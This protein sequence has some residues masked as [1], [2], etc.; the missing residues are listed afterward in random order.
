MKKLSFYSLFCFATILL[1]LSCI[2]NIAGLNIDQNSATSIDPSYLISTGM[3]NIGGEYENTRCVNIHASQFIQHTATTT[4][5][6]AGGD[7]YWYNMQYSGAYMERH[8]T[9]VAKYFS[10]AIDLTKDKPTLVN[11]NAIATIIRAFDLHRM[12]DIYGDIPYN[13]AGYGLQNPANWFPTYQSQQDVYTAIINDVKAA[14]DK[15]AP[16]SATVNAFPANQDFIYSG[17]ILKWKKFANALLMRIALR[18]SKV[19]PTVAQGVFIEANNSGTFDSNVD[20][21]FIHYAGNPSGINRNGLS[22]GYLGV[23]N[24]LNTQN[25]RISKTFVD[26]MKTNADPRLLIICGG[27]GTPMQNPTSVNIAVDSQRGLPNGFVDANLRQNLSSNL[28]PLFDVNQYNIFSFPN[29]KCFDW[30]DPYYLITYSETQFM[31]AEA[32]VNGWISTDATTHFVNG[33]TAAIKNWVSF[34]PNFT[35]ADAN[36]SSYINGRGF[37]AASNTD[38]LRLI[39][40]EYWAATYLNDIE[41]W[42]NWRR[43]GYPVLVPTMDPNATELP[44]AIPRRLRYYETEKSANEANYLKAVQRMGGDLFATKVWW[45]GGK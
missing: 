37:A 40:E 24:Y 41:S 21:A 8:F 9:D 27:I 44:N 12:T 16:T 25:I 3:L 29:Y 34:D 33:V 36:I 42:S 5:T 26:W 14:R 45:D 18:M 28:Q 7:K 22:D 15:L 30:T 6:W 10:N 1:S 2:P 20:N 23:T 31:K 38:K 32:A 35:T 17:D 39:G 4:T 11:I 43:T 13:Q 19:A